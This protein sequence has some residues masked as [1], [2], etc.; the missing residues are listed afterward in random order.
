LILV[1]LAWAIIATEKYILFLHFA[2]IFCPSLLLVKWWFSN[3]TETALDQ[4]VR[5]YM[6]GFLSAFP[7]MVLA[8]VFLSTFLMFVKTVYALFFAAFLFALFIISFPEEYLK[9]T[10]TAKSFTSWSERRKADLI[11]ATG[12][13]LGFATGEALFMVWQIA[14]V[15]YQLLLE[16]STLVRITALLVLFF[17][18]L[19]CLTGYQIGLR[20]TLK[21]Y[22]IA[23]PEEAERA[24][25]FSSTIMG[26]IAIPVVLRTS[27]ICFWLFFELMD[28]GVSWIGGVVVNIIICLVCLVVSKRL[29]R[30]LPRDYLRR[31]GYLNV[32]GYGVLPDS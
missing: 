26:I 10:F 18:P 17:V 13:A 30:R 20:L 2:I 32:M 5:R 27:L 8:F 16:D 9:Y 11:Y 29:E 6:L 1:V 7:F 23:H 21:E 25:P 4:L 22:Y 14:R 24:P 12:A 3:R 15:Q 19:H 28:D 31:V